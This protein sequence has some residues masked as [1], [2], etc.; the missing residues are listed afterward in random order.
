MLYCISF[1]NDKQ[2]RYIYMWQWFGR[3]MAF[4]CLSVCRV[5]HLNSP[6]TP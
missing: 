6:I 4:V 5:M 3:C 1:N 2:V